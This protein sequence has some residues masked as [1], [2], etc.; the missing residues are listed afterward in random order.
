MKEVDIQ[1][2][3]LAENVTIVLR[4]YEFI[5]DIAERKV[6]RSIEADKEHGGFLE[7]G[8]CSRGQKYSQVVSISSLLYLFLT[9]CYRN[10][11]LTDEI[12]VLRDQIDRYNLQE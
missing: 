9:V 8:K 12:K 2:K 7:N 11:E 5:V 1:F 6:V 3:D 10:E 4:G